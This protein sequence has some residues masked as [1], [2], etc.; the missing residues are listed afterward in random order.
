[1]H[2]QECQKS[3]LKIPR[4]PCSWGRP[5]RVFYQEHHRHQDESSS[6]RG[7]NRYHEG[8]SCNDDDC[9]YENFLA[10]ILYPV[11]RRLDCVK[12]RRGAGLQGHPAGAGGQAAEALTGELPPVR[13]VR[14][15]EK[16][17]PLA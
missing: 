15:V 2:W 6:C 5:R 9:A 13:E 12:R 17:V 7:C 14:L 1:M 3:S 16:V 4:E 11:N 8:D 10:V